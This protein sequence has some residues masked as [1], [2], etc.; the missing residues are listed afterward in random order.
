MLAWAVLVLCGS[1]VVFCGLRLNLTPSVPRGLY[2]I[3]KHPPGVGAYV[4]YCP[5][6]TP[7]FRQAQLRGYVGLGVCD[8][9][10]RPLLKILVAQGG[11]RFAVDEHGVLINGEYLPASAPLPLD[12]NGL[13][14]PQ[15]NRGPVDLNA[16]QVVLMSDAH[17]GGFDARYFGPLPRSGLQ[18]EA[19]PLLTW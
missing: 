17:R 15:W 6:V 1:G 9:G 2:W 7:L 8:G 14:L 12:P 5:P 18:G 19:R 13:P 10:Y 11:D 16:E 4:A 3:S